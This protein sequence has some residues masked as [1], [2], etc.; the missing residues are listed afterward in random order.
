MSRGNM[1]DMA[2]ATDE[3]TRIGKAMKKRGVYQASPRQAWRWVLRDERAE[4]NRER[5]NRIYN[6]VRSFFSR[7]KKKTS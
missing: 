3:F 7:F 6:A 2:D 4:R 1:Q 5:I